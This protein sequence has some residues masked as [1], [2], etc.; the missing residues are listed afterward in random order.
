M[1]IMKG[2]FLGVSASSGFIIGE[3]NVQLLKFYQRKEVVDDV[4]TF[5]NSSK[6]PVKTTFKSES[7]SKSVIQ[8]IS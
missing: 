1:N 5:R 6:L 2:G 3:F 7:N 4:A 8:A